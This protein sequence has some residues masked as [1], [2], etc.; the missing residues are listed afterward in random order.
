MGFGIENAN[1]EKSSERLRAEQSFG[2][3]QVS[4]RAP[5][6]FRSMSISQLGSQC[7]QC[8]PSFKFGRLAAGYLFQKELSLSVFAFPTV[9]LSTLDPRINLEK[10]RAEEV[11]VIECDDCP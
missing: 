3:G 11:W 7:L 6:K 2:E 4:A 5:E 8:L 9:S 1:E 10:M